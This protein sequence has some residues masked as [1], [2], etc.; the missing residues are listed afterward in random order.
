MA[1]KHR[2]ERSVSLPFRLGL[3]AEVTRA[4]TV[5]TDLLGTFTGEVPR[6]G[7]PGE[8][9]VRKGRLGM[10]ATGLPLGLASEGSFGPDPFV[11]YF[12]IGQEILV[13]I[14]DE[15]GTEVHEQITTM[16]TNFG[17]IVVSA[18]A[19]LDAFLQR[20]GFPTHGVIVRPH[21]GTAEQGGVRKGLQT[22]AELEEA[23]H[24]AVRCSDDGL[25]Q[26]ETD[27]R[28]HLN[29]TRARVIRRLAFRLAL[30]LR[31]HCPE[32]DAPGWGRVDVEPGLPCSWC[33]TPTEMVLNEVYACPECD[34][35]ANHPRSDGLIAADPG[36]CSY[37]NP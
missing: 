9:A 13:F 21:Q 14:D 37:C 25:A 17:H 35:R 33:T 1:T 4:H 28:A 23:I 15:R 7:S 12:S 34:H 18:A 32:C 19:E 27:M 3:G 6:V 29:P 30:R 8:V 20:I 10:A 26:V 31:R 5:D 36:Q 22:R 16:E 24:A 11:R 2:K